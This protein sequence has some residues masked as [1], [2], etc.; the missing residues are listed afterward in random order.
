MNG[1]RQFPIAVA[2]ALLTLKHCGRRGFSRTGSD[3]DEPP[4]GRVNGKLDRAFIHW[5]F[6]RIYLA[7][8]FK[9]FRHYYP[10]VPTDKM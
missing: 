7:N 9:W 4:S 3:T 2:N 6:S 1:R 8:L 10:S 5:F